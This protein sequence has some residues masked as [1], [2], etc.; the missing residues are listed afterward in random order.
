MLSPN[1]EYSLL[2]L[3]FILHNVELSIE[4]W[5]S[6]TSAWTSGRKDIMLD[7][8]FVLIELKPLNWTS[9]LAVELDLDEVIFLIDS[10]AAVLILLWHVECLA[11]VCRQALHFSLLDFATLF[12]T[13]VLFIFFDDH[14]RMLVCLR[15]FDVK[16]AYNDVAVSEV[17]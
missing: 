13:R 17:T 2:V 1:S 7:K 9:A 16:R 10:F 3:K 8:L 14:V 12:A 4:I 11:E 15:E 5:L 6:G